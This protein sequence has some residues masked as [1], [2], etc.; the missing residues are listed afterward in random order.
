MQHKKLISNINHYKTVNNPV[1]IRVVSRL[2]LANRKLGNRVIFVIVLSNYLCILFYHMVLNVVVLVI[3][4][5]LYQPT[6]V[7]TYFLNKINR[8]IIGF[9]RIIMVSCK[10]VELVPSEAEGWQPL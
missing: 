2:S 6:K 5:L 9:Y 10:Q 3:I 4:N 1:K 8:H 7:A